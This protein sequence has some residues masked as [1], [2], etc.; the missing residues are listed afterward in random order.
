MCKKPIAM[1]LS[2]LLLLTAL[3][4][5]GAAVYADGP[6]FPFLEEGKPTMVEVTD[7]EVPFYFT[8]RVSEYYVFYSST[9]GDTFGRVCDA[10]GM[11]IMVDDDGG[12]GT[13]FRIVCWMNAGE[14]YLLVAGYWNKTHTGSFPICIESCALKTIVDVTFGDWTRLEEETEYGLYP[15]TTVYYSDGTQEVWCDSYITDDKGI[16]PIGVNYE[17]PPEEWT[18]GNTYKVDVAVAVGAIEYNGEYTVTVV[19]TPVASVEIG[20][21]GVMLN[22]D[23]GWT[24]EMKWNEDLGHFVESPEYFKYYIFPEAG[25]PEDI[26]ITLKDGTV[27]RDGIFEWN[28]RQYAIEGTEQRYDTRLL[29]GVNVRTF[30]IAG[31]TGTYTV[32]VQAMEGHDYQPTATTPATCGADGAITYTCTDCGHSYTE[33]IPA[34]GAH[35]YDSACDGDCGV[36]G[37]TRVP[38]H[39]YTDPYDPD[40]HLCGETR[41]V[42]E[43][44]MG[45]INGDGKINIRDLGLLQQHLNHW[46][47]LISLAAADVNGDGKLNI[48]DL[49]LLQQYLNHWDVHLGG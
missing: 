43:F 28:G 35:L 9:T 24:T 19:D 12:E 26:T 17:V 10:E 3:P 13:N 27:I 41:A 47:V 20:T 11:E 1:I 16:Y 30:S 40:C 25:Y 34:T 39:G 36:C 32:L 14:T 23:G 22:E 46:D 44:Q 33:I 8:P 31:Y 37:G 6:D 45:D 49:G 29:H 42:A 18:A 48:R 2:V 5:G 4:L 15:Y 38:P 21:I 7:R